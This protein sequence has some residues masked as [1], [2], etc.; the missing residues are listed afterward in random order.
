M[1]GAGRRSS[2]SADRGQAAL[3][4]A[5]ALPL[6]MVLVLGVVQVI[7]VTSHRAAVERLAR[8][9]ARAASVSADPGGAARAAVE[10][11]TRLRPVEVD[12][13][14]SAS[15]VTVS[16]RYVDPTSV[17]VVGAVIGDVALEATATMPLEPP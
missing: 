5:L 6:V 17:P 14:T 11:G 7:V 1:T 2:P 16:V 4:F 9:G 10:R 13:A 8:D 12:T 15:S 3:E